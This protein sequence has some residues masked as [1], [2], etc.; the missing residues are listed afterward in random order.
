MPAHRA[1][2]RQPLPP[3]EQREAV[4]VP[5]MLAIGAALPLARRPYSVMELLAR[6]VTYVKRFPG[7]E[8][9]T[10]TTAEAVVGGVGIGFVPGDGRAVGRQPIVRG[11]HRVGHVPPTTV[12]VA[13]AVAATPRSD[14]AAGWTVRDAECGVVGGVGIGRGCRDRGGVGDGAE[15][16]RGDRDAHAGRGAG[17]QHPEVAGHGPGC[18]GARTLGSRRRRGRRVPRAAGRSRSL[19]WPQQGRR[20]QPSACR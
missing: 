11:R 5:E 12:E 3:T 6:L 17:G 4:A 16:R 9:V 8:G 2:G 13:L 10:V 20:R 7:P 19:P 15:R 18:V 1:G 14:W